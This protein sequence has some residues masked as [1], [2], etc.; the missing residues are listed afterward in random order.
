MAGVS[1]DPE[2]GNLMRRK[3]RVQA[4]PEVAVLDRLFVGGAPAVLLPAL[5]PARD[6]VLQITA[7]RVQADPA[8]PPQGLERHDRGGEL[9]AV[10]RRIR[11]PALELS[12]MSVPQQ[13]RTPAAGPGIAAAGPVGEDLDAALVPFRARRHARPYSLG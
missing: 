9:H 3:C 4:P 5:D 11:H 8:R 2:P 1:L 13:H 7:V 6:P 12:L 10:V